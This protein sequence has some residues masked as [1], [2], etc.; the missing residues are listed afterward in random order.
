[1][2]EVEIAATGAQALARLRERAF[3]A[4]TLDLLLPDANGV[5]VL[6]SVRTDARNAKIPVVVVSLVAERD[7]VGGF[8]VSDMFAKPIDAPAFLEAVKRVLPQRPAA[9]L[10][11]AEDAGAAA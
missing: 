8:S 6:A 1:G 10:P 5:D 7:A 3:D 9:P 4:I 2:Y 11:L